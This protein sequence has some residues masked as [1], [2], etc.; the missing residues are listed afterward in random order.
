M[1]THADLPM[2]RQAKTYGACMLRTYENIEK[3][4]CAKEFA[5][6]KQCVQSKVRLSSKT[7]L[8]STRSLI[9]RSLA[10]LSR[11]AASGDLTQT[12]DTIE[13]ERTRSPTVA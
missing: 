2:L 11:S 3:D 10:C 5:A 8:S 12:H 13:R 9:T 1:L 4:A 6:F 7:I